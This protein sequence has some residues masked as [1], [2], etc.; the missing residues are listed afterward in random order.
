MII[1]DGCINNKSKKGISRLVFFSFLNERTHK[2]T[3]TIRI[4][5]LPERTHHPIKISFE[6]KGK[7]TGSNGS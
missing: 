6:C 3:Y 4:M 1:I 7:V 5:V 2:H